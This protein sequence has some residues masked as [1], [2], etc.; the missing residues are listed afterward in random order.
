MNLY[1]NRNIGSSHIDQTIQSLINQ[2][3][4]LEDKNNH[5]FSV[6]Q[7]AVDINFNG[8]GMVCIFKENSAQP[9]NALCERFKITEIGA[10]TGQFSE[11]AK[12]IH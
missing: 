1:D 4:E 12:F 10:I 7:A 2:D 9:A 3:F 6:D 8:H 11:I 5:D